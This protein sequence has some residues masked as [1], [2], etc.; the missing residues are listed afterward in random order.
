LATAVGSRLNRDARPET[1]AHFTTTVTGQG[2]VGSIV[3]ANTIEQLN[4]E[5]TSLAEATLPFPP[6]TLLREKLVEAFNLDEL[7]TLAQDL[8]VDYEQLPGQTKGA[9]ARELVN[10][11]QRRG[12]LNDLLE[13]CHQLR[14]QIAWSDLE[15]KEEP[16]PTAPDNQPAA[17]FY[18]ALRAYLNQTAEGQQIVTSFEAN[19]DQGAPPLADY[20]A[21]R[22][23]AD[24][25]LGRQLRTAAGQDSQLVTIVN[26]A[27]VDQIINIAR[28][29]VTVKRPI[30]L[31]S[32]VSQVAVFLF[33]LLLVGGATA[34][35]IWYSDRPAVMTG[36]FNIAVAQFSQQTMAGDVEVAPAASR[37]IFDILNTEY[38]GQGFET[39]Q[40]AHDRIGL[41]TNPAEAA[42]LAEQINAQLVIYGSVTVLGHE[43]EITP[44]FYVSQPYQ[45]DLG[46]FSGQYT[47][48]LPLYF[49]V[50]DL[51][52][53]QSVVNTQLKQRAVILTEYTKALV[54]LTIGDLPRARAAI[55][56][57]IAESEQY[58]GLENQ[59]VLY[60]FASDI[61][62]RQGDLVAAQMYVDH[63]LALD[64]AYGRAYIARGNIYY[65]QR[66][67]SLAQ[68]AYETALRLTGQ[69]YG[70]YL[71]EKANLNLGNCYLFQFQVAEIA[72]RPALA[73]QA[74]THFQKVID[75]VE[76]RPEPEQR[77]LEMAAWAYYGLGIIDQ[78][79]GRW[80]AA[81]TNFAAALDRTED[82]ELRQRAERRLA[83]VQ[84]SQQVN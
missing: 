67:F 60:L 61:A 33:I 39:V 84:A 5:T 13:R 77:L 12:R 6:A 9:V 34:A 79:D 47:L 43:A 15:L 11:L 38:H 64:P 17:R 24:P 72:A 68:H 31:F 42:A 10:Y 63:A 29:G 66:V 32:S 78:V 48:T 37:K 69:P 2:Q 7:R 28:V 44:S 41:I 46:E 14:P 23:Q 26:N 18:Q 62:R 4:I 75:L 25:D 50:T 22:W 16:P 71:P 76:A 82:A 49:T 20:L 65:D 19:P 80:A 27:Q 73:A 36:D 8:K 57:A 40:V 55:E 59:E 54:Y 56:T 1:P 58:D 74:T 3:N 81:E 51:L 45:G 53:P 52:A 35:A 83:E 70:A 30:Q 21:H